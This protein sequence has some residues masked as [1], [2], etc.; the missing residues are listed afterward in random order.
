M[1]NQ[2]NTD[3]MNESSTKIKDEIFPFARQEGT[4][5]GGIVPLILKPGAQ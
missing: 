2:I 3:D 5:N 4:W 1:V